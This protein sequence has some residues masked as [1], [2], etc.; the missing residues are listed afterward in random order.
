[1]AQN[2]FGYSNF[3]SNS[4]DQRH[5]TCK[6]TSIDK[7]NSNFCDWKWSK[8]L[9]ECSECLFLTIQKCRNRYIFI[10]FFSFFFSN[11]FD[12]VWHSMAM[13]YIDIELIIFLPGNGTAEIIICIIKS[14]KCDTHRFS[15][16]K[17]CLM[18]WF[19]S[20]FKS[21]A[22][23]NIPF[24][25]VCCLFVWRFVCLFF[26]S[27][28]YYCVI[29]QWFHTMSA[30]DLAAGRTLYFKN[31]SVACCRLTRKKKWRKNKTKIPNV[32]LN[33]DYIC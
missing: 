29:F 15:R 4:F 14:T 11:E 30:Y 33:S 19:F 28:F 31:K 20:L 6:W 2:P 7:R 24:L 18:W 3:Q 27:S 17:E 25:A 16:L 10:D 9:V 23:L 1:M 8:A 22:L 5:K 21:F 13:R 32:S 12:F 26:A